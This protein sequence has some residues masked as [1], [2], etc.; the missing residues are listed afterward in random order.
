MKLGPLLFA[1]FSSLFLLA[2]PGS[3]QGLSP[4]VLRRP[5]RPCTSPPPIDSANDGRL[6]PKGTVPYV[7]DAKVTPGQKSAMRAAMK[8]WENVAP[9][10]F[11][12]RTNQKNYIFIKNDP[13]NWSY[14]GMIGGRQDIGIYNWNY[15]FIMAHELCHALGFIHEQSRPDRDNYIQINWTNINPSAIDNFSIDKNALV[16]C[17]YDFD[18][19]MHYPRMISDK[20]LVVDPKKPAIIIKSPYDRIWDNRIGQE[21]HLSKGDILGMR[22][23]YGHMDQPPSPYGFSGTTSNYVPTFH[24]N[25]EFALLG[26]SSFGVT[27]R[28]LMGGTTGILFL[29]LDKASLSLPGAKV[30][31]NLAHGFGIPIWAS[32]SFGTPGAGVS[33]VK[34]PLPNQPWLSETKIF[35]QGFFFEGGFKLGYTFG[36]WSTLQ[37]FVNRNVTA[38]YDHARYQA[39]FKGATST[40]ADQIGKTIWA[41]NHPPGFVYV[42]TQQFKCGGQSNWMI[43]VKHYLTGIKFV[44]IPG[45]SF[46]MGDINGMGDPD[47][48]PVHWVHLEPFL[49]AQTEI[50]Q[51]QF[52]AVMGKKPWAGKT[53]TQQNCPTCAANYIDWYDASKFCAKMG[54]RLP[55]ESE[56]EYACRAGTQTAYY[57]GSNSSTNLGNYAWFLGSCS[58]QSYPHKVGLKL[59]NAF[60]LYD[61]HGN[62]WEWCLDGWHGDYKGALTNGWAWEKGS[63]S[64]RVIRG[65]CWNY[66]PRNCRSA[67]RGGLTPGRRFHDLGFRPARSLSWP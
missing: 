18:S 61:M 29:S 13:G 40:Q 54:C 19:V 31:V 15:K 52:Y 60:G 33:S 62:V 47:E 24:T 5:P 50:T 28:N 37:S 51:G 65:G 12:P 56:W 20:S 16:F 39:A 59:P 46:R 7:F 23:A 43:I 66:K 53:H 34:I 8:E 58:N 63:S 2:G 11:I 26:N 57:Y 55:S 45:G 10:K 36:I 1:C 17:P 41:A 64:H 67:Y 14:V 9:V 22:I 42:K 48:K 27:A 44:L 32:G 35:M 6:W 49:I 25:G 4:E 3:S 30:Y 21:T 38:V